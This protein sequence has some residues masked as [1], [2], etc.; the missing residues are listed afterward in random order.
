MKILK[1]WKLWKKNFIKKRKIILENENRKLN[2]NF[3]TK[4]SIF[5]KKKG[6][7]DENW[8]KLKK[9]NLKIKKKEK[10]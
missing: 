6:K 7:K 5:N 1:K 9:K 3:K 2:H 4:M 10:C 8:K